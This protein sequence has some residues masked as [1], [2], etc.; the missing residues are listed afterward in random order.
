MARYA[1]QLLASAEGFSFQ[2]R[3]F[4]P[5]G[6]KKP[7]MLFWTIVGPFWC[8]VVTLVTFSSS[9]DN[10]A[11]NKKINKSSPLQK[12]ISKKKKKKR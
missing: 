3:L 1:G 6:Q 12:N 5:F 4:L 10:V 11:K 2:L 8:S 7:Y 9:L